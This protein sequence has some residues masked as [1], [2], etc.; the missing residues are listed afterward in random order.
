MDTK[1]RKSNTPQVKLYLAPNSLEGYKMDDVAK[2]RRAVLE[3]MLKTKKAT[4]AQLIRRLNV[5]A[6]FHKNKSPQRT[7]RVRKDITYVQRNFHAKYAKSPL[8]PATPPPT[9]R[10]K[11]HSS[12]KPEQDKT[13]KKGNNTTQSGNRRR[14]ATV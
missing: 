3:T 4:Y 8:R 10:C 7:E 5:L 1:K 6:I 12:K 2:S 14:S 9:C 11:C 13:T